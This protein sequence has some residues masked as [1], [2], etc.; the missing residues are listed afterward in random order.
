M[1]YLAGAALGGGPALV[2][3]AW[4]HDRVDLVAHFARH[5]AIVT[6]S[7]V[8][9]VHSDRVDVLRLEAVNA[10]AECQRLLGAFD[11]GTP[12]TL[13]VPEAH[14]LAGWLV[15]H[16]FVVTDHDLL[17][18]SEGVE[19]PPALAALHPGLA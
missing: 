8:V 2:P 13:Y 1:L 19:L 6:D 11:I 16:E 5:G 10:V 14:E 18:T 12:V 17:C 4:S 3:G 15:A 9:A 7:A